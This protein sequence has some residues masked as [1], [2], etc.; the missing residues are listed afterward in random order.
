MGSSSPLCVSFVLLHFV[1]MV[2]GLKPT[3]VNIGALFTFNSTIG[4]VARTAIELAVED[5]NGDR[6][7][8][9]G[10][11]LNVITQDTNCSGFLGTIEGNIGCGLV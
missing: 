2:V 8:L 3:V 6:G 10:T 5:V 7:V 4:A 1:A 9:A 11:K